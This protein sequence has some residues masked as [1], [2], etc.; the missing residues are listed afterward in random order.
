MYGLG[1]IDYDSLKKRVRAA[2]YLT[3]AQLFLQQNFL[4]KNPLSPDDIKPRLLGHWGTCHGINVVYASLKQ[5]QKKFEFILGP[6][7][8]FPALQANLFLDG[9]LEKI[10]PELSRTAQGI[11][12]LCREFSWPGGFPSHASPYTPGVICEGGELGYAL[13]E[14][15]GEALGHPEKIIAVLIGDGEFETATALASL[16]LI[17]L[18]NSNAHGTVLPILHL[19]GYKISGPTIS[20]RKS[21]RELLGQIRGFGYN[22][23]QATEE[24]LAEKLATAYHG[25]FIIFKSEKGEGGPSYVNGEKVAGNYLAHQIPLKNA[26]TDPKELKTLENWLKSYRFDELFNEAGGFV[27]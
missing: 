8:G 7:H 20:G 23:I 24:N 1:E 9:D 10:D 3:V 2:D 25:D 5:A 18:I 21:E 17:K 12:K 4:L 22:P 15:Y 13:A 11:T 19:N 26:K 16:N 27:L 6:G 14:A